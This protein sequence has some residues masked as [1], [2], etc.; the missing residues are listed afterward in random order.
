MPAWFPLWIEIVDAF[1]VILTLVLIEGLLS[2][3]NALVIASLASRLPVAQRQRALRYG[4][5][6]AYLFRGL[7]LALAS[8]IISNPWVKAFGALYLVW[9]MCSHL[10]G[11]HGGEE[12]ETKVKHGFWNVFFTI[13]LIDLSLSLDNVVAAVALSPKLWVVCTGV[14]IGILALRFLS[15][16]CIDL[17]RKFPVLTPAA[18]L[19]VGYVGILLLAEVVFHLHVGEAVKFGGIGGI[20]AL[21]L[22]WGSSARARR[23]LGPVVKAG[24]VALKIGDR[25]GGIVTWPI[26]VLFQ[27]SRVAW[28]RLAVA[29]GRKG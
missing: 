11:D 28:K 19:L 25:I 16:V 3:D 12:K 7:A 15:G 21:S 29:K 18:F 6:G 8:W 24:S 17:I 22:L 27:A 23:L 5:I 9:L 10:S 4:I 14:F 26:A 20:L 13:Q 1:P 2:V